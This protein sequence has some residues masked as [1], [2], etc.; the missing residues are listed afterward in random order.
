[1]SSP[2]PAHSGID[3]DFVVPKRTVVS[4]LAGGAFVLL[5]LYLGCYALF[6]AAWTCDDTCSGSGLPPG[7]DW[8][9]YSGAAQWSWISLLACASIAIALAK[10][11][12][13]LLG[14]RG[15]ASVLVVL[16][17]AASVP[18]AAL[19]DHAHPSF[20]SWA[21]LLASALGALT[22]LAARSR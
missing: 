8:I 17:A 11:V 4:A 15:T 9:Q 6:I 10:P 22:V 3:G 5:S 20:S 1:M 2:R 12:I 14:R 7:A 21:W 16:F 18:L 19:V 13:M